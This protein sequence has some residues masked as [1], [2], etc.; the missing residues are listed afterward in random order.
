[1]TAASVDHQHHCS[2]PKLA[3]DL[4]GRIVTRYAK[5]GEAFCRDVL[6]TVTGTRDASALR[7]SP[8]ASARARIL[9]KVS[10]PD[11]SGHQHWLGTWPRYGLPRVMHAG[12]TRDVV[13]WLWLWNE[14]NRVVE[15]G[16]EE[17]R[18]FT[19]VCH[20]P[21]CISP[22]HHKLPQALSPEPARSR[23]LDEWEA[24][25]PRPHDPR[26]IRWL[27]RADTGYMGERCLAGHQIKV[28]SVRPRKSYCAQCAEI[29]RKWESERKDVVRRAEAYGSGLP[30]RVPNQPQLP[31]VYEAM[32][33]PTLVDQ[34]LASGVWDTPE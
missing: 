24:L 30:P 4:W 19:R 3:P 16:P 9:A 12:F 32:P 34:L 5:Y 26:S 6:Q 33:E 17:N 8:H 7:P 11:A 21:R 13:Q 10:P 22:D 28:Y 29:M 15:W 27:R 14:A 23:S 1:M 31:P 25:H 2:C 18:H 20:D